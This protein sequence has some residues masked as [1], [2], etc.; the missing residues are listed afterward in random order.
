MYKSAASPHYNYQQWPPHPYYPAHPHQS[1]FKGAGPLPVPEGHGGGKYGKGDPPYSYPD[2]SNMPPPPVFDL[3]PQSDP[4]HQMRGSGRKK[5]N[6]VYAIPLPVISVVLLAFFFTLL[7]TQRGSSLWEYAGYFSS[8]SGPLLSEIPAYKMFV[9][10]PLLTGAINLLLMSLV[11][12]YVGKTLVKFTVIAAALLIYAVPAYLGIALTVWNSSRPSATFIAAG[13]AVLLFAI[14]LYFVYAFISRRAVVVAEMVKSSYVG[15]RLRKK[16]IIP[17]IISQVVTMIL[18]LL[19]VYLT[20]RIA[21]NSPYVL[22]RGGDDVSGRIFSSS[23]TDSIIE[24]ARPRFEDEKA[25]RHTYQLINSDKVTSNSSLGGDITMYILAILSLAYLVYFVIT[26]AASVIFGYTATW[27]LLG[28]RLPNGKR[29]IKQSNPVKNAAINTFTTSLGSVALFS[30]VIFMLEL[31]QFVIS[32]FADA[33]G[34]SENSS[35]FDKLMSSLIKRVA[36]VLKDIAAMINT[37][38]LVQ[39]AIYGDKFSKCFKTAWGR[40][41]VHFAG[42]FGVFLSYRLYLM[43]TSALV[44]TLPTALIFFVLFRGNPYFGKDPLDI[45]ASSC[46]QASALDEIYSLGI[47]IPTPAYAFAGKVCSV[48]LGID[49]TVVP[50]IIAAGVSSIFYEYVINSCNA[51]LGCYVESPSSLKTSSDVLY[52]EIQKVFPIPETGI[53]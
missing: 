3:P 15:L 45:M 35:L 8:G 50:L 14:I 31:I 23:Y 18:F 37:Y 53:N 49:I 2:P 27:V 7:T 16:S 21:F 34:D 4:N 47:D 20:K 26:V 1:D 36:E 5:W 6:D 41:K 25:F 22:L 11:N 48:S 46:T 28:E 10:F 42:L 13:V 51:I 44:S 40:I 9:L 43:A 38:S 30:L 12:N 24:L 39:N 33:A 17:A 19:A 52:N 32:M 29:I